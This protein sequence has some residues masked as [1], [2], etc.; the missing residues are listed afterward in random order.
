MSTMLAIS[1]FFFQYFFY[2]LQNSRS[3]WSQLQQ[4]PPSSSHCKSHSGCRAPLTSINGNES[5]HCVPETLSEE[6]LGKMGAPPK[7]DAPVIKASGLLEAD[8][9]IFGFPTRFGMMPAQFKAFLDSTGGLWRT[10]QL[11]GKPAALFF[12]TGTQGGGQETTALTAITQLVHHGMI[13][14]PTGYTGGAGM[15]ELEMVR[16]GSPYGAGTFAGDGSRQ[17]SELELK[18]AF[19]QGQYFAGL[20]KKF[21]TSA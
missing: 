19:H 6:V 7:G 5:L 20:A 21:R 18:L 10:Q 12:S 8:G 13:F 15:S 1:T 17:P 16:G 9:F 2:K 3:T 14:V 11:A 4:G